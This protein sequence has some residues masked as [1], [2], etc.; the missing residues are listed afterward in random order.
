MDR[1]RTITSV[2]H[3]VVRTRLKGAIQLVPAWCLW[4]QAFSLFAAEV[5]LLDPPRYDLAATVVFPLA[6]FAAYY[7][8]KPSEGPAKSLS[9]ALLLVTLSCA[10]PLVLILVVLEPVPQPPGV[11]MLQAESARLVLTALLAVCCLFGL[12]K[13]MFVKF[14]VV[15]L[16]Y[17]AILE[18]G[19]ILGGFFSEP[20][21]LLYIPGLPAPIVNVVG[22][23]VGLYMSVYVW[24][25]ILERFEVRRFRIPVFAAGVTAVAICQDLQID[26][27]AT[28]AEWWIWHESLPPC[29]LGVP[30]LN[31][32][33]W[34]A[35]IF[36]FAWLYDYIETTPGINEAGRIG[37]LLLAIPVAL[38]ASSIIVLLLTLIFRGPDSPD[39]EVFKA[40]LSYR[41]GGL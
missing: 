18:N 1:L 37:R 40:A 12:S 24:Q 31:F 28:H 15:G 7:L 8:V 11:L 5:R 26:P 20:G 13:A 35:T 29:F 14:F 36:T 34:I 30:M 6:W 16:L 22:W 33:A 32:L 2:V 17:G 21:Y 4:F 41:R 27:Y 39:I 38:V 10:M 3:E 25:G 23:C 19:G 9:R